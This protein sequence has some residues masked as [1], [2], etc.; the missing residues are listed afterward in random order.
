MIADITDFDSFTTAF[1]RRY[2]NEEERTRRRR[3]FER[4]LAVINAHTSSSGHE[5]SLAVNEFADWT[6][7]EYRPRNSH[8]IP[9]KVLTRTQRTH[10]PMIE[11]AE[12]TDAAAL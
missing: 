11:Q 10:S 2:R 9:Q 1:G 3:I 8:P 6:M 12:E 5:F 4:N 7:A